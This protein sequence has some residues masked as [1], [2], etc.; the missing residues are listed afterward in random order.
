MT[1]NYTI[2]AEMQKSIDAVIEKFSFGSKM[3]VSFFME[4]IESNRNEFGYW[5]GCEIHHPM[6]SANKLIIVNYEGEISGCKGWY[7]AAED[8]LN[9]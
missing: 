3:E 6:D 4:S 8:L 1:R 5:D 7:A 2:S 9:E